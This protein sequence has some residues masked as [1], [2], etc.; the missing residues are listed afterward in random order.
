MTPEND[1][2]NRIFHLSPTFLV[3]LILS[4]PARS[5]KLSIDTLCTKEKKRVTVRT[6][7]EP[8][9]ELEP[10]LEPSGDGCGV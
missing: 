7:P 6:E 8:G 5:Q 10:E 9:P 3:L 4:L 1:L 2:I